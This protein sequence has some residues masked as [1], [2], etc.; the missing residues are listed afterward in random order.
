MRNDQT[1]LVARA[2]RIYRLLLHI[3]PAE[4]RHRFSREMS[5]LFQDQL[6]D[7]LAA[8]K[9]L[10]LIAFG[11]RSIADLL[12][13]ALRERWDAMS[14]S[15]L[16]AFLAATACGLLAA[17]SDLHNEEVQPCLFVVMVGSFVIALAQ[18][19][20]AWR[21]AL[22]SGLWIGIANNYSVKPAEA[23]LVNRLL[24][25][26]VPL[27]PAFV[28]AYAGAL[29]SRLIR[30]TPADDRLDQRL[31]AW[32]LVFIAPALALIFAAGFFR[33]ELPKLLVNPM[34]VVGGL[35]AALVL[36]VPAVMSLSSQRD[37]AGKP[38]ITLS[39]KIKTFNL[40]VI[41][42]SSGV[43]ISVLVAYAFLQKLGL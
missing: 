43:L 13:G 14:W 17:Y 36:N 12:A 30:S 35:A 18:P 2:T 42:V 23:T 4:F 11:L 37:Q 1:R 39:I 27:I 22:A 38:A 7:K 15:T 10:E 16:T 8:P 29:L 31:A 26:I 24:L 3:Y 25:T 9:F 40:A 6:R 33:V 41:A 5:L 19:A 20:H 32:A 28:G 34:T 21:W